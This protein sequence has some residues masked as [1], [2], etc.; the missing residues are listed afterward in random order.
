MRFCL[1]ASREEKLLAQVKKSGWRPIES[2][3]LV[4]AEPPSRAQLRPVFGRGTPT[5]YTT[6]ERFYFPWLETAI[7]PVLQMRLTALHS[8]RKDALWKYATPITVTE[9]FRWILHC[10]YKGSKLSDDL[11]AD[12]PTLLHSLMDKHRWDAIHRALIWEDHQLDEV[13]ASVSPHVQQFVDLGGSSVTDESTFHT[14]SAEAGQLGRSR[15]VVNKPRKQVLWNHASGQRLCRSQHPILFDIIPCWLGRS[16]TPE[17]A[18]LEFHRR[19]LGGTHY[20]HVIADALFCTTGSLQRYAKAGLRVTMIVKANAGNIYPI[21]TDFLTHDLV[22]GQ[23]RLVHKGGYI[24]EATAKASECQAVISS[25]FDLTDQ[26]EKLGPEG[27]PIGPHAFAVHA[28][29]HLTSSDMQKI[30]VG[31][32]ECGETEPAKIVHS[33]LG[34]DPLRPE[35]DQEGQDAL[36]YEQAKR[37]KRKSLYDIAVKARGAGKI[38]KNT[39]KY[40]LLEILF[41]DSRSAPEAMPKK[42][43]RKLQRADLDHL[44]ASLAGPVVST[45]SIYDSWKLEW[46]A[47]DRHNQYLASMTTG[48][49]GQDWRAWGLLNI[50]LQMLVNA[51]SIFEERLFD[52]DAAQRQRRHQL[53]DLPAAPNCHQ[54]LHSLILAVPGRG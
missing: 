51:Q 53:H 23:S 19:A 15:S 34:W 4:R 29:H 16:V 20:R 6:I 33:C 36:E 11:A 52:F 32:A 27:G 44:R 1:L 49:S 30:L 48:R 42:K 18:I 22:P 40:E 38:S 17:D 50:M 24:I 26:Q 41:P 14:K 12:R 21:L 46:D 25:N 47:L 31:A 35:D 2:S 10:A 39:P 43:K 8:N 3:A 54:W 28:Y 9:L 13:A 45:H 37:M 7:L 5:E